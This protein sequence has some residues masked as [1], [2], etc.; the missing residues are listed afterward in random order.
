MLVSNRAKAAAQRKF[1]VKNPMSHRSFVDYFRLS[2]VLLL[3]TNF[4][5]NNKNYQKK[6]NVIDLLFGE[7]IIY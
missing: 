1:I 2:L 4:D 7:I 3:E 5:N 6:I